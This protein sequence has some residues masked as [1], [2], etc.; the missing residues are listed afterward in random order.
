MKKFTHSLI[1]LTLALVE[2]QSCFKADTTTFGSTTIGTAISDIGTLEAAKVGS[3]LIRLKACTTQNLE[4]KG[5][6]VSSGLFNADG[7]LAEYKDNNKFGDTVPP[8][9]K[10]KW[11]KSDEYLTE[12]T[13]Y[14]KGSVVGLGFKTNL[15]GAE[16]FGTVTGS[17]V[18]A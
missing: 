10:E 18:S 2:A 15:N 6:F 7:T 13:V 16:T 8:Y 5:V 9:C 11:F 4:L 14:T 17:G 1:S 3:T 12:L